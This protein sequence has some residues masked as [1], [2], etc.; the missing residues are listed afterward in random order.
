MTIRAWKTPNTGK[1]AV[2]CGE[3]YGPEDAGR[4]KKEANLTVTRYLSRSRVLRLLAAMAWFLSHWSKD[5]SSSCSVTLKRELVDYIVL[6][7]LE[8]E[9]ETV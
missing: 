5:G 6:P 2:G 3:D 8:K 7:G 4:L 9:N 1:D